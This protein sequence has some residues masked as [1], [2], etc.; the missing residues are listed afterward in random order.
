MTEASRTEC[1]LSGAALP[2]NARKCNV[3]EVIFNR[4]FFAP[5]EFCMLI[6]AYD[7]TNKLIQLRR[8]GV[9]FRVLNSDQH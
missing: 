7:V 6:E 3:S 5:V 4:K 2:N 9:I 1:R 8:E